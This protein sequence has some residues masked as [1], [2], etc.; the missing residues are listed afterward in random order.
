[1]AFWEIFAH[2]KNEIHSFFF[3]TSNQLNISDSRRYFEKMR[4]GRIY[5]SNWESTE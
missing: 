4:R 1:M 3:I 5:D 2:I